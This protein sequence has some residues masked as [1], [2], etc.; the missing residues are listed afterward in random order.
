[1]CS[2]SVQNVRKRRPQSRNDDEEET[3]KQ[4][5]SVD[6]E[7]IRSSSSSSFRSHPQTT[8]TTTSLLSSSPLQTT[9]HNTAATRHLI[10]SSL[11]ERIW[12]L[13]HLLCGQWTT[14]DQE[15]D[16]NKTTATALPQPA[17]QQICSI[18]RDDIPE[19]LNQAFWNIVS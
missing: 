7:I 14:E 16:H 5:S 19:W 2:P 3:K 8:T 11:T 4:S 12:Q 17:E 13:D 6:G 15:E 9:E 10:V 1:M 18:L